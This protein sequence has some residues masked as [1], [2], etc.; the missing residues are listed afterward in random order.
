MQK[1]SQEDLTAKFAEL[2]PKYGEVHALEVEVVAPVKAENA[3]QEDVEGDYAYAFI[4][5]P[6]RSMILA[7]LDKTVVQEPSVGAEMIYNN[8][9]IKEIS[10]PRTIGTETENEV[11][12]LS[13]ILQCM[14]YVQIYKAEL[15]KK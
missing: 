13:C 11:I 9:I 5:K 4:R 8:S 1:L 15:K 10:D 7:A 2:K 14:Q 6:K 12:V 3:D